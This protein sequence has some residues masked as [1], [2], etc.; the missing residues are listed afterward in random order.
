MLLKRWTKK[1]CPPRNVFLASLV[2]IGAIA[3]YNWTVAPHRNY[4]LAA[5]KYEV[6]ADKLEKNW[7]KILNIMERLTQGGSTNKLVLKDSPDG[8]KAVTDIDPRPRARADSVEIIEE[9]F[10][11][12]RMAPEMLKPFLDDKD[13]RTRANAA[14]AYYAQTGIA[15]TGQLNNVLTLRALNLEQTDLTGRFFIPGDY[16][17]VSVDADGKAVVRLTG[18]Q[19]QAPAGSKTLTADG[20]WE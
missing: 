13:N 19:P 15:L 11:D 16:E 8:R 12:S 14:K 6:A 18:S 20:R 10:K 7:E 1:T 9:I 3:A 4:L 2:L 17:I 5:R